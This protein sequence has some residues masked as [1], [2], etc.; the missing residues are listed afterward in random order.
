MK[1]SYTIK[2]LKIDAGIT[3]VSLVVTIVIL[4]ILSGIAIATLG[5][6]NGLFVRVKQAK[7]AHVQSEMQEQLTLALNELQIDKKGNAS[8]DDV[9][10]DWINTVISS[11]YSPT[12]KEDASIDG[13]MVVMNKNDIT[14]RFIVNQKLEISKTEFDISTLEFEYETE[15][16]ENGKVKILIKITDKVNGLK[17]V[18]YPEASKDSIIMENR[19]I[20]LG[21]DYYV[22]LGKEYKFVITTGD[23]NKTE[24][25]IKI[26]DFYY[27]VTKTLAENAVI[28]N[29]ATKAAYNKTYEA[30]VATE[31]NYAITGL[32]VTMGGQ[33][34]TTAG[35]NV[36]DVNTGKIKIEKVTGDINIT[37]TTKKLEIQY[38]VAV[39]TSSSSSNTSS[40]STNSVDKGTT[41]YINIIATLEG[42]RCTAVLKSD[43]TKTVPYVVNSNGKYTFKISGTYNGKTVE[44]EK[45]VI[46]NQYMSA[47]NIVQYDAGNWTQAEIQALQNKNLY[48]INKGKTYNSTF[49]L[50]DS[51]SGLNFT[52]GGFTYKGDTTNA[53]DIASG[54]I[55]TSRNQSVAP[56]SGYGT[57]KY[58]GWQILEIKDEN[59]NIISEEEEINQKL[60]DLNNEKIYI[61]KL[62]HAGSP[63]NFVYYY[64]KYNDP[65][66]AAYLLSGETKKNEYKTLDTGKNINT[67]NMEMYRDKSLDKKGFIKEVYIAKNEEIFKITGND[68]STEGIRNINSYYITSYVDYGTCSLVWW[69]I[70]GEKKHQDHFYS[71]FCM[72]I[73]PVIVM[74]EGVYIKYG[75]GTE[76]DPYIL[77]KD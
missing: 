69:N 41:L 67:R 59:E 12:I 46:V 31:G 24:K 51:N 40:L 50:N 9:T 75:S 6:E 38:T 77:G 18:D 22:E 48:M 29:N 3:L 42:N 35:N 5:G 1:K 28:D 45:E 26:D 55:I 73:R 19:K 47:K 34:V 65:Y 52:F 56:Q 53:S 76:A 74:N 54:N 11:D 37:V 13:K 20:P 32:T 63:E 27:N 10:Q 14:G 8:L 61:T 71:G 57:P 7:K 60:N 70:K 49:N 44:E 15:K 68:N 17:R 2:N 4:L 33:T 66:R 58:S 72:G 25:T 62:I 21:I 64:T 39:S 16:I 30:T 23:G 43:N 36:V